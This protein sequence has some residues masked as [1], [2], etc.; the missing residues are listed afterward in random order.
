MGF[1]EPA[2]WEGN[3]GAVGPGGLRG[4]AGMLWVCRDGRNTS[5]LCCRGRTAVDVAAAPWQAFAWHRFGWALGG[6]GKGYLSRAR[7]AVE[8][9]L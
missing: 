6:R 2:R 3:D 8:E 5:L 7:R 9:S 4:C 1:E